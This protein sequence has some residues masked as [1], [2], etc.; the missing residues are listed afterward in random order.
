MPWPLPSSPSARL[1]LAKGYPYQAPAASYRFRRGVADLSSPIDW[2]DDSFLDRTPVIAHGSNRA[3]EQLA[4]KYGAETDPALKPDSVQAPASA[5]EIPVTVTQ[6]HDYEVVYSA[7]MTRYGAVAANLQH[8]PGAQIEV[9][10]TW[11]NAPQLQR[12]HDTELGGEIYR[13]GR[14]NDVK[15]VQPE[16]PIPPLKSV[17]VYLSRAGCLRVEDQPA[18]IAAIPAAQRRFPALSQLEAL[19]AVRRQLDPDRELDAFILA[20]VA[21]PELRRSVIEALRADAV[22]LEAP[23]FELLDPL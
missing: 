2:P 23:H 20:V 11:L 1:K 12:M 22:A 4:R 19:E 6:L 13:F 16:G 8:A 10:I 15:L 5:D 3:P 17:F 18:G 21:D 7:H 9:F 14:L